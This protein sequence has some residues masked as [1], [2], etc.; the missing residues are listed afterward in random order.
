MAT[1]DRCNQSG[2]EHEPAYRFTWPGR[3]EEGICEMHAAKLTG[4]AR[5]MG[6]YVQLIPLETEP[7]SREEIPDER[8]ADDW[9]RHRE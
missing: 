5:A 8:D 4:V 6:L 2:C 1:I 9:E 7:A 3:D